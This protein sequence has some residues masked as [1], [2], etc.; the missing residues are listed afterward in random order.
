MLEWQR[1]VRCEAEW[2]LLIAVLVP[3]HYD[4]PRVFSKDLCPASWRNNEYQT[5]VRDV[6]DYLETLVTQDSGN[7]EGAGDMAP[8]LKA[9]SALSGD[10][11][12]IPSTPW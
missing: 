8:Q 5:R 6:K 2:S 11:N 3:T 9:P 7:P 4:H 1:S 10:L 12:L